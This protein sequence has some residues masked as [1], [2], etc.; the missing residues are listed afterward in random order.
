MGTLTEPTGPIRAKKFPKLCSETWGGRFAT[1]ILEVYTSSVEAKMSKEI[2]DYPRVTSV[3]TSTLSFIG[4][5][6][7]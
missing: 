3:F 6:T 5:N 2:L 7:M 1:K 4:W